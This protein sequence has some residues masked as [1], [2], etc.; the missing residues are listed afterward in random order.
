MQADRGDQ[1]PRR[2]NRQGDCHQVHG[3]AEPVQGD[4]GGLFHALLG[5]AGGDRPGRLDGGELGGQVQ[6][7]LDH[8]VLAGR[9][10]GEYD[11]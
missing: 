11:L 3:A 10:H 4:D 9:A 6:G 2:D 7:G 1:Q 8:E 5:V